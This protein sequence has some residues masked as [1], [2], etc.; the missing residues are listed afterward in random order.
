MFGR[1]PRQRDDSLYDELGITRDSS[2][3]VIK[4]SYR[5]LALKHH[6]DKG[7]DPEKFKKIQAAY[8]I[9]SDPQQK[10]MYDEY[11]LDGLSEKMN[12]NG[13]MGGNHEDIFNMFFGG[14]RRRSRVPR[15]K[16]DTLYKLGISLSDLYNGKKT[17]VAVTR[18]VVDGKII[19]CDACNG[20]GTIRRRMQ[21]GPGMIQELQSTCEICRGN[22][23]QYNMKKERV[24]LEIEIK[25]GMDDNAQIRHKGLGNEEPGYTTGDIV[26]VVNLKEDKNFIK[27]GNH[28]IK[29]V[30]VSL[31][32]ALIGTTIEI[33]HLD[34][35][36]IKAST[37]NSDILRYDSKGGYP[38][39]CV[40]NEGMPIINSD[41]KGNM[42]ILFEIEFPA[43]WFFDNESKKLLE[44]ILPERINNVDNTNSLELI[45]VDN[46]TERECKLSDE[47]DDESYSDGRPECTQS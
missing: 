43:N 5:K 44:T 9:L 33:K 23:K 39:R 11:G 19:Y 26:F 37:S 35:R 14:N 31:L 47:G 21:I 42:I 13:N 30:R 4:K 28:L 20:S 17:K 15:K 18:N 36:T 8:D 24:E 29:K 46:N 16:E 25:K 10:N 32:E 38:S 34:G 7:G 40:L 27:K 41:R 22:G 45:E 12:S 1:R 3:D 2:P 6:P